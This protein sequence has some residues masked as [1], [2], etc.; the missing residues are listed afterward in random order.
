MKVAILGGG[1]SGLSSYILLKS[2][3]PAPPP[4]SPPHSV[5]ILEAYDTPRRFADKG[6][7]QSAGADN[8]VN[9][10][11]ADDASTPAP[12]NV[13]GGFGIAANGMAVLR[14]MGADLHA[15]VA[16]A[17]FPTER[18][19]MTTAGAW[20][21]G[22]IETTHGAER[23]VALSW[24]ALWDELR[25]E[26]EDGD[27]VQATV[28]EI[29]EAEGGG[30]VTVVFGDGREEEFDLVVGADGVRSVARK[31]VLGVDGDPYYTYV[32]LPKTAQ[33]LTSYP[34]H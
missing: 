30:G 28:N 19:Q 33:H 22:A 32:P 21:L 4:P 13:G 24:K 6:G 17:G 9:A 15:R 11:N 31:A 10:D 26:V 7:P 8:A 16:A 3:L 29:R 34:L 27:F 20:S 2:H 25:A 18:I 5:T 12:T 14:R 1:I 23:M